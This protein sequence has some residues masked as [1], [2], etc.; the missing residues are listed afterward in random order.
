MLDTESC[1]PCEDL[2]GLLGASQ[3]PPKLR[4]G[5]FD[6]NGIDGVFVVTQQ[7]R[8]AGDGVLGCLQAPHDLFTTIGSSRRRGQAKDDGRIHEPLRHQ[9]QRRTVFSWLRSSSEALESR[10]LETALLL[11][12]L[13]PHVSAFDFLAVA[14]LLFDFLA[15]ASLAVASLMWTS[16]VVVGPALLVPRWTL[17]PLT[18]CRRVIR[19]ELRTST[20]RG[21]VALALVVVL[22]GPVVIVGPTPKKCVNLARGLVANVVVGYVVLFVWYWTIVG[23]AVDIDV[24]QR[25]FRLIDPLPPTLITLCY[26]DLA[27]YEVMTVGLVA[28]NV[29]SC[30]VPRLR[31]F[32]I[33]VIFLAAIAV[34]WSLPKPWRRRRRPPSNETAIRDH[35]AKVESIAFDDLDTLFKALRVPLPSRRDADVFLDDDDRVH[36][37]PFLQWWRTS[38][39]PHRRSTPLPAPSSPLTTT[40]TNALITRSP[41]SDSA[42]ASDEEEETTSGDPLVV[43]G[44]HLL[45]ARVPPSPVDEDEGPPRLAAVAPCPRRPS[46]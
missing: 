21:M 8:N 22:I 11:W 2:Q 15:V 16:L 5:G 42:S 39:D 32:A 37:Q 3:V 13:D 28:A 4:H 36:L 20:P 46:G 43:P 6:D 41:S 23:Y 25:K 27:L 19:R 12:T 33:F 31:G 40:T 44:T 1:G 35:F 29:G 26:G 9:T 38:H 45:E 18:V 30:D 17:G 7:L 24:F 10:L 34:L 14:S